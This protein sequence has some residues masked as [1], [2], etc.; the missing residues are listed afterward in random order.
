MAQTNRLM[1]WNF[2]V[3]DASNLVD[4]IQ[5]GMRDYRANQQ[6]GIEN[7]R[8]DEQMGMQRERFG[9]EREK[10]GD[11]KAQRAKQA[12]G[13][14]ALLTLNAAGLDPKYRDPRTGPL[15]VLADAGMAQ[16]YLDYRMKQQAAKNDQSRL[17]LAFNADSR[18]A[19]DQ[20]ARMAQFQNMAPADRANAAPTLG[21]RQG[22]PEY[23]AFIATGQYSPSS[24]GIRTV[25][26]GETLLWVPG[27]PGQQPEVIFGGQSNKAESK[28]AEAA[29]TSQVSRY[30]DVVKQGSAQ[31]AAMGTINT[32]RG[33]SDSIGAPGV[34]NTIARTLGP[35]LRNVGIEVGSLSDMEAFNA[36]VSRLVPAQRPPGSG[37]MSDKDVDLFKASLPQLA[38]TAG[39]R[40]LILDQMEAI[41]SYDIQRAQIT[42]RALNGEMPRQQAEKMLREMPD[43]MELFRR[44]AGG[45]RSAPV[46]K[47]GGGGAL[48]P[49]SYVYDPATGQV[50][51]K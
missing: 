18:A 37:T 32:L 43:P 39:G 27:T 48:A 33:L 15:A 41:A 24:G 8:A 9:M 10:F 25:K 23:N 38:A 5:Q 49:G 13:N 22:T 1:N 12:A 40:K 4:P 19:A 3:P 20:R 2:A 7:Q 34:G 42:S 36:I 31:N 35:S 45:G 16:T 14:L 44:Q 26:E 6:R 11:A 21:L 29:A 17:G 47:P 28:F 30:D 51:P 50:R 46:P